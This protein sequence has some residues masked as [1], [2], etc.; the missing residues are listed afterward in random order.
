MRVNELEGAEL[1]NSFIAFLD[2]YEGS[3]KP[4][5]GEMEQLN[6]ESLASLEFMLEITDPDS[7][8]LAEVFFEEI[9]TPKNRK[10][11]IK[12]LKKLASQY[13]RHSASN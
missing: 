5:V 7:I 10:A 2:E 12:Y 9:G 8:E 11:M 6:L 3:Y 13:E 4:L 1:Y